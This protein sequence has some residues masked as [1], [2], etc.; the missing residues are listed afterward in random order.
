MFGSKRTALLSM[1]GLLFVFVIVYWFLL[2]PANLEEEVEPVPAEGTITLPEPRYSSSISI[3]GALSRRRSVREYTGEDLSI[4]EISQLLWAAQGITDEQGGFRTAPSAGALYP[5]ELYLVNAEGIFR[6]DAQRHALEKR[7]TG[8]ARDALAKAALSQE[9]VANA[10][11]VI[12]IIGVFERTEKKYGER[13]ERYVYMEAGHVAQNIYLQ[14]TSL[15]LGTVSI[16]AFLDEEVKG[17]L[18]LPE[19]HKPIYLMPVGH[20]G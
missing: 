1:L 13:G 14:C 11:V 17:V 20:L 7:Y 12:V 2:P 5:I 9:S 16:G 3:E 15:N 8:D 19:D 18:K 4:E 10:P 6:Y